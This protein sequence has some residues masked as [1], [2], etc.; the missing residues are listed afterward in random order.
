MDFNITNTRA[1]ILE[2]LNYSVNQSHS[3]KSV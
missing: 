2:D 1:Q 3:E